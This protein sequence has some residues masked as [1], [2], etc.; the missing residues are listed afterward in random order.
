MPVRPETDALI[1]FLKEV[2]AIDPTVLPALIKARV[3]CS[4]RFR[5]HPSIQVV[6]NEDKPDEVGLLGLLN[7]FCGTVDD[8]PERRGWGPICLQIEDDGTM[9][10]RRTE[11]AWTLS[12]AI[13]HAAD[14]GS[15]DG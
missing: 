10:F 5:T 14:K 2:H 15:A 6:A 11:E 1:A 4:A 13:K 7:G 8:P 9:Q 12:E 3:P